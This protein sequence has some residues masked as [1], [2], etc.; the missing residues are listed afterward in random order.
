[1]TALASGIVRVTCACGREHAL[2]CSP[3]AGDPRGELVALAGGY[4]PNA[5]PERKTI[6][7]ATLLRWARDGRL[8]AHRLERGKLVAWDRD[9]RDAVEADGV[10]VQH[11]PDE[12]SGQLDALLAADDLEAAPALRLVKK[13]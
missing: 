1:V 6:A 13:R 11:E 5:P 2:D 8:V 3:P 7:G 4:P 12:A 9:V 10:T